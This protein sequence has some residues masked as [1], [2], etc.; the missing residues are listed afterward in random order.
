MVAISGLIAYTTTCMHCSLYSYTALCVYI[1]LKCNIVIMR[2]SFE[3]YSLYY[4]HVCVCVR[5]QRGDFHK[6][7]QTIML[8][9]IIVG[10]PLSSR[11]R[12]YY[13][14]H[15][16]ITVIQSYCWLTNYQNIIEPTVGVVTARWR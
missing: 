2:I 4:I 12:D 14:Y 13:N 11:S 5:L 1:V 7:F 3:R 10:T 9:G 6:I 8:V 16:Y 15:C